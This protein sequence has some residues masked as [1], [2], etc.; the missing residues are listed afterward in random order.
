VEWGQLIGAVAPH[1]TQ[2]LVKDLLRA[3]NSGKP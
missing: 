2:A 3:A 1:D